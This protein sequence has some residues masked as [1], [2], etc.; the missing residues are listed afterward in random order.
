MKGRAR[1]NFVIA[2]PAATS[3]PYVSREQSAKRAAT[4]DDMSK[5]ILIGV[6]VGLLGL[7]AFNWFTTGEVVLIPTSPLS[8]EGRNLARLEGDFATA[9]HN[10]Y[11]AGH[12]AGMTGMDT[13]ADAQAALQELDRIERE[14]QELK[15]GNPSP[16]TSRR[17]DDLLENIRKVRSN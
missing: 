15:R 14:A 13:T 7:V 9:A 8:A 6:F 2:L 16:A 10:F 3:G 12:S 17:I 5:K 1:Y 4:G 11:Q